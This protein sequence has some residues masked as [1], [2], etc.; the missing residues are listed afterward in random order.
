MPNF[1]SLTHPSLQ[2][3]VTVSGAS[4]TKVNCHNSRTSD[5]TDMKFRPVTTID[6]RNK[7]ASKKLD[8]DVMLTSCDVIVIFLIYG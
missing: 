6:K 8:N 5:V 2:S 1:V 7:A 3:P 4:L